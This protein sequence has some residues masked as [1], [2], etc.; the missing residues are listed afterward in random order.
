MK[1]IL[2]FEN[3]TADMLQEFLPRAGLESPF[4]WREAGL[5]RR[6]YLGGRPRIVYRFHGA[7]LSL[8]IGRRRIDFDFGF[9]GRTGGFNEWW[10]WLF[11]RD[12][13]EE[14]SEFQGIECIRAALTKARKAGEIAQPFV[15]RQDRLEYRLRVAP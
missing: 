8:R 3:E 5:T 2:A 9:D 15:D 1:L 11:A 10:L 6:G 14:F 4:D 13:S 12:R 7:G